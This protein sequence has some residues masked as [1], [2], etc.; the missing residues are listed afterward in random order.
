MVAVLVPGELAAAQRPGRESVNKAQDWRLWYY[1]IF[2]A[3]HDKEW[4]IEKSAGYECRIHQV[5]EAVNCVDSGRVDH[6][7]VVRQCPQHR[8]VVRWFDLEPT[9]REGQPRHQT[10][11]RPQ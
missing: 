9:A 6:Q 7:R 3:I 2:C 10:D 11:P 8:D 5:D 4:R 1:L